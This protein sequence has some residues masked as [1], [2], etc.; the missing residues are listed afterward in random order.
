LEFQALFEAIERHQAEGNIVMHRYLLGKL[1]KKR[2]IV[3]RDKNGRMY[4]ED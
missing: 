4:H 1:P 2:H 3:F